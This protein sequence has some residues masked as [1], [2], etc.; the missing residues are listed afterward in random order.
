MKSSNVRDYLSLKRAVP[1]PLEI[2]GRL[3]LV[4][5]RPPFRRGRPIPLVSQGLSISQ[6]VESQ[7]QDYEY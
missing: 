3:S 2:R 5:L 1:F 7:E 4:V 6:I